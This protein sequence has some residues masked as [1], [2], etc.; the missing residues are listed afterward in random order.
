MGVA[1]LKAG[2]VVTR[3][4]MRQRIDRAFAKRLAEKAT[5]ARAR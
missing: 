1:S 4:E 2:R 3:A 5:K